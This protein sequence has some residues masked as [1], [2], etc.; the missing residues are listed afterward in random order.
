MLEEH[1]IDTSE[2]LQA[3]LYTTKAEITALIKERERV[4]KQISR[5][6][7]ESALPPLLHRHDELTEC[8]G[9]GQYRINICMDNLLK[10]K[11]GVDGIHP[12]LGF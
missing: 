5:C 10:A 4:Y 8:Y 9:D 2:Q 3:F 1:A 12:G 7:D 6:G 11:T